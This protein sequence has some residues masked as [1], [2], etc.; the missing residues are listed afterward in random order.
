MIEGKQTTKSAVEMP[1][2]GMKLTDVYYVLFRQKWLIGGFLAAGLIAAIIAYCGQRPMYSSEAKLLLRYVVDTKSMEAGVGAQTRSL[3]YAGETILNSELEILKSLDLCEEVAAVVGAER[4]LGKGGSSND[5]IAAA[6]TISGGLNVDNPSRSSVI[7]VRFAH[8]DPGLCQIVLRELIEAYLKRHKAIHRDTAAFDDIL[9]QEAD[10]LRA[11]IRVNEDELRNLNARAG[12]TSVGD[13]KKS[14]SDQLSRARQEQF[15][16]ETQIAEFISILGGKDRKPAKDEKEAADAGISPEKIARYKLICVHLDALRNKQFDLLLTLTEENLQVKQVHDQIDSCEKQ[17]RD[18]EMESPKLAA[19]YI[20]RPAA[21]VGND[22]RPDPAR[23]AGLEARI[24]KLTNHIAQL[25]GEIALLDKLE[26]SILDVERNLELDKKEYMTISA[27]VR[28]ARFDEKLSAVKMSN[29]QPVQAPSP[30]S[31]NVSQR[32]KRVAGTFFGFLIAGIACA[33]LIE[34]FIDHSVRRPAEVEAKLKLPLFLS[35]PKLGLDGHAKLLPFPARIALPENAGE[36]K[37][38]L[39]KTW[40]EDHPLRRYI[41]GLRDSTL[42]YF[43]GDPHKPKLIGVTSCSD[44]VGVTSLA[45]G[46]AG[47]LSETG[48]GNV[49]LLNLNLEAQ[50]VHPFYRGELA[51][52]LAD[53]LELDKRQNGMV[54]HNLYVA[55]AGNPSD[56]TTT[57]LPKQLAR[58]VPQL[59]VSD[60]DYIVFDL[61]PTTPTTMTARLA[62]MMDLVILVV[63]SEKD[64]QET[65]K[66]AAKLLA[67]SR[68]RV[69]A[70]LNKVRNPVPQWLHKG[71]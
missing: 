18:L 10:Q 20:P 13:A 67:R 47:A 45:A 56:P 6:M 25:R 51:C 48:E 22:N 36:M 61:P 4:V 28:A 19:L 64:T 59:R 11:R 24:D 57:N 63:E 58:V 3:D 55:T 68:A 44:G 38:E 39:H 30:P 49:L 15:D 37:P 17:K 34:M 9:A 32:L 66:Q 42:A 71:A 16:A 5:V 26:S 33:F 46:L 2:G 35:I 12:V 27:G 1:A 40:A 52:N 43:G 50:A 62:G 7:R 53:A 29:I 54:L 60:Y 31:L 70:V 69:S 41:D 14:L 65:V 8:P 21:F 23:I